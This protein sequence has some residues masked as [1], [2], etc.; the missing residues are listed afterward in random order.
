[1]HL[2]RT[3]QFLFSSKFILQ[4][5]LYLFIIWSLFGLEFPL[6]EIYYE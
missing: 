3:W 1:M 6:N 5:I 2:I 4:N